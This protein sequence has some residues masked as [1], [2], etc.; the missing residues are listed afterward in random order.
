MADSCDVL[1]HISELNNRVYYIFRHVFSMI[2]LRPILT[3]DK[4]AFNSSTSV[5]INYSSGRIRDEIYI[6]PQGILYEKGIKHVNVKANYYKGLPVLFSGTEESDFPFDIFA[7][8]FYLITRYEEYLSFGPDK[9]GRFQPQESVA[10]AYKFIEEPIVEKWIELLKDFLK[11]RY[12]EIN[13]SQPTFTYIPTIDVDSAFSYRNKGIIL[14]TALTVRDLFTGNF[15]ELINRI[16][17]ILHIQQD[18]F[19]NFGFLRNC[20]QQTNKKVIFFF[21]SGK[22]GKYDKNISL[23]KKAM[24]N[25]I[26][27]VSEYAEIGLHPSYESNRK[28]VHLE[29]EKANLERVLKKKVVKSRQHYL[30]MNFPK[31]FLNLVKT[32]IAEDYSV[33]YAATTGFRAGTCTPY[34]FYDLIRDRE[35]REL[36]IYPF[37]LMDATF[38]TYL[39]QTAI[40]A[41]KKIF[42]YYEKIKRVNGTFIMIWHNDTF[43]SS[44]EDEDWRQLFIKLLSS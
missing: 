12:P 5:K 17:A 16:K 35:E 25:I 22:R 9:F 27:G 15:R 21:L 4:E 14:G 29:R 41:E 32:G 39:N 11:T 28:I 38:K 13:F 2:G 30:K 19:D 18:P 7:A 34:N 23:R 3:N 20:I 43:S 10:H 33:G 40:E 36:K 24:K 37:Q 31:T 42:E 6:K 8:I 26:K 1:I 44:R